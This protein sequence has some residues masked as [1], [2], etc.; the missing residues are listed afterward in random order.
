MLNEKQIAHYVNLMH[1][2]EYEALTLASEI[3]RL[4]PIEITFTEY[5]RK[6]RSKDWKARIKFSGT[7]YSDKYKRVIN[8]INYAKGNRILTV[9]SNTMD[10]QV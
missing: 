6:T 2:K 8:K 1:L 3:A 5:K 10:A 7:Y 9:I 4:N